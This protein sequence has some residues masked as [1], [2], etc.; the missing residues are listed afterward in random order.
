MVDG[1]N[2]KLQLT[3]PDFCSGELNETFP[4]AAALMQIIYVKGR[5]L[6]LTY[7]ITA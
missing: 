7:S 1:A 2:P 4:N 3:S 5:T 6:T